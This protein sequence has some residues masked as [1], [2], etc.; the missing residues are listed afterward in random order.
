MSWL[1]YVSPLIISPWNSYGIASSLLVVEAVIKK[2]QS[3][4]EG[5]RLESG[6]VLEEH[7]R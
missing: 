5:T 7:E 6:K 1:L 2:Q 4:R 3:S